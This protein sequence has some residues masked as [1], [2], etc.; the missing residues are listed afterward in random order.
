MIVFQN[1]AH[2]DHKRTV[3]NSSCKTPQNAVRCPVCFIYNLI[4]LD[5]CNR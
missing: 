2:I 1:K 5:K 4:Y 3:I